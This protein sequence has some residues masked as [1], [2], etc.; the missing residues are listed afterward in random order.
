MFDFGHVEIVLK[1]QE[2]TNS[3]SNILF[4]Y[5]EHIGNRNCWK[6]RVSTNPDGQGCSFVDFVGIHFR[7]WWGEMGSRFCLGST[8]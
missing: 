8:S 4:W 2:H 1:I 7:K 5:I 3:L 6:G